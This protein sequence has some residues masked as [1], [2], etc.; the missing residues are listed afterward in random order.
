MTDSV[1]TKSV[2]TVN[3][4]YSQEIIN[5]TNYVIKLENKIYKKKQVIKTASRSFTEKVLC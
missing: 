1:N 3:P 4:T 5:L 2:L